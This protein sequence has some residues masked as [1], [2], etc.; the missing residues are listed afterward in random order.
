MRGGGGQSFG[1]PGTFQDDAI[2]VDTWADYGYGH[3][4]V[5]AAGAQHE[6]DGGVGRTGRRRVISEIG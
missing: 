2:L 6:A 4:G 1:P 3:G 5:G